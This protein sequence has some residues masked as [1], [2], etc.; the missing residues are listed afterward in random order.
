MGRLVGF[1]HG[2][3]LRVEKLVAAFY[4][5]YA[6]DPNGET[7]NPIISDRVF[8]LEVGGPGGFEPQFLVP[9]YTTT[10]R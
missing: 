10:P 9:H 5:N 3:S 4:S 7:K 8:C 2:D 6:E 1:R